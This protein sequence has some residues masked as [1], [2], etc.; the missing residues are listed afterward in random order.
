MEVYRPNLKLWL[1]ALL[2]VL[3]GLGFV[4]AINRAK[5]LQGNADARYRDL[6]RQAITDGD[7][8]RARMLYSRLIHDS[9]SIN[10]KDLFDWAEIL[11]RDGDVLASTNLIDQ[12]APDNATG[13][14]EAHRS[15]AVRIT[16]MLAQIDSIENDGEIA[17]PLLTQLQHHL[18]R[19]GLSNPL[20]LCDLWGVYYSKTGQKEKALQKLVE[21]ADYAPERWL[22]AAAA[23]AGAG[24]EKQREKCYSQAESHYLSKLSADPLDH[25]SRIAL[26][27]VLVETE[28]VDAASTLLGEGLEIVNRPE[29]RRAASDLRLFQVDRLSDPLMVDF[30]L[31]ISLLA[32]AFDLD[33]ANPNA[34]GR[35]MAAF[36]AAKSQE[37]R[38]LLRERLQRLVAQGEAIAFAHFSLGALYWQDNDLGNAIWHTEKALQVN[39]E[40]MDVANNAAWLEG[41]RD[42]GDRMRALQL[43]DQA[44]EKQPNR[45]EYRDTKA[46]ILV[47]LERWDQAL[48]ELE[49]LLPA[50]KGTKRKDLHATLSTVYSALGKNELANMHLEEANKIDSVP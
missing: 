43:I 23:C 28:R 48:I 47:K 2:P 29:L 34:Y 16:R 3:L 38:S 14:P 18:T 13:F 31:L 6:A 20:Q 19:S 42:G 1:L 7:Y 12:L 45:L 10:P 25:Q 46:M 24:D 39:P 21:S 8:D 49:T 40:L 11:A 33:P 32:Q 5:V 36:S 41:Q 37:Q 17:E 30:P 35:L 44:I 9:R 22:V 50:T 15:K 27:K 26:A 4:L